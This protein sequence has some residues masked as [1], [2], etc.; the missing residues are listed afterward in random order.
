MVAERCIYG[1]DINPMAVE[2]AK[3]SLW[4]FTMDPQR[5]LSFLDHHLKCGNA[6]I[7]AWIKDLGSLPGAKQQPGQLNLFEARFLA[8]IPTL[9][10]NVLG[11]MHRETLSRE[12]IADKKAL[13]HAIEELKQ[14]FRNIAHAWVATYFGEQARDYDAWLVNP[15][16]ARGYHS[17]SAA[18]HRFFH[19]ELEFPEIFFDIRGDRRKDK[20]FSAVVGNPP[21]INAMDLNKMLPSFVKPFW[22]LRFSSASGTYDIYVLFIEQSIR[23]LQDH[24]RVALIT[25]NKYLSAPYAVSLRNY[26]AE[27]CCVRSLF[28]VSRLAIFDDPSVYPIVSIISRPADLSTEKVYV[29]GANEGI[30]K[31]HTRQYDRNLLNLLPDR[32]WGFLLSSGVDT[33]QKVMRVSVPFSDL[34]TINASSTAAESDYYTKIIVNEEHLQPGQDTWKIVNT[35]TIDPYRLLWGLEDFSHGGNQFKRP[36]LIYDP[37]IVSDTRRSQYNRRKIIFS[38]IAKRI[39]A[40]V[41]INGTYASVNTNFAIFDNELTFFYLAILNSKLMSWVYEQFFGALRMGGGYLQFQAPQLRVLP[42]FNIKEGTSKTIQRHIEII[43]QLAQEATMSDDN[44]LQGITDRI[45]GL[46]FDLYGLTRDE[47]DMIL[48]NSD[49]PH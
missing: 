26:L 27:E 35:G 2:L 33:L 47:R 45:D 14:P 32:I 30:K 37:S 6:L 48:G 34:A 18:Q 11:I 41:D 13:D 19:W 16:E 8:Q 10:G 3:L 44:Q 1:V 49:V 4:L 24:G 23:L 42:M 17:A 31:R 28:D 38:K 12:D 5:P 22:K 36:V 20:G 29:E 7:G 46:V 40:A 15:E 9:V 21:Y 43:S 25:P 39:E